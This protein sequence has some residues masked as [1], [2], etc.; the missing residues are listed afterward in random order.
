MGTLAFSDSAAQPNYI[1]KLHLRNL[2]LFFRR[3]EVIV[4]PLE[5]ENRCR[6]ILREQIDIGVVF[7]NRLVIVSTVHCNPVFRA[8]Q[9]IL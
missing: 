2:L 7:P 6:N 9:L 1:S 4:I 5:P 8:G 3:L